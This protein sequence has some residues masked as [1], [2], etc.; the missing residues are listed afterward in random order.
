MIRSLGRW[1][2]DRT[3]LGSFFYELLYENIPGGSRW[4]YVTG[5]MLVFAF[6]V[7]VITGIVLWMCYS[8]GSQ[9]AYESVYWIQNELT[10]GW[11]LRGI[12]HFMAQAMV[13]LLPLHLLQVVIDKAYRPPREFNFWTGLIL[14]L[15]TLGLSLTGYLLPW[16]QKGYWATQVATNLMTLAPGGEYVQKL[17][18]GGSSYGHYTLTRFF[19]LHTGILPALLVFFLVCHLI[20]FRRHGITAV[21]SN[22][23][24]QY[25]WPY[26]V[27]KDGVACLILF[28]IVLLLVIHFDVPGVL[29]GSW[30]RPDLGAHLGPPANPVG[31]YRAA[32]PEWYFL[33]LF[34]FLKKF[35]QSEVFGA[36]VV[37]SLVLAYLFL[38]PILGR[39]AIGHYVNVFVLLGLLGGIVYLTGESIYE[40]YYAKWNKHRLE[41]FK[42]RPDDLARY[43]DRM[44]ASEDF[45][46]AIQQADREYHRLRELVSY[47]GIPREG[48]FVLLAND[49]EIQGPKLFAAKCASCHSYLDDNKQGIAGPTPSQ[50]GPY[51]APNL[52][53]FASRS[54]LR[55]LLDPEHIVTTDY[56]GGT[57]HGWRDADGSY[58]SGGM[59]E[60][61][62]DN[63]KDL[64]DAKRKELEDLIAM[65][66]AEAALPYQRDIDERAR[67]D[68]TLE[69]GKAAFRSLGCTDCH[70]LGDEGEAVGPDLTGYGSAEWLVRMISNPAHESLYGD[71][72]D[73]MPAFA[74]DP[75]RPELNQ[76]S[77]QQIEL[78]ARWIRRDAAQLAG[79]SKDGDK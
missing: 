59:V 18:I 50:E 64:S 74:P 1:I 27:L 24:D 79:T 34:Q 70:K 25:F 16:D 4:R 56:F 58:P 36:I 60:F 43:E 67:Q 46:A 19:A 13:A 48:A 68:G 63:L 69:R 66:S 21:R 57:K 31:D 44:K 53:G 15:I 65:L 9:N 61:V 23:P 29:R 62:R 75:M 22:R 10:G 42:D 28:V 11:L 17:L 39:V 35:E 40:D 14:M 32:R 12:H 41:E 3:G 7:Q 54:W 6:T 52:Y 76:L 72:N 47:Y 49:P 2:E 20:L 38:M 73:R 78:L 30:H 26:Q 77:P 33:F 45:L 55:G 71:N 37:P 5:S 51:G 8:P